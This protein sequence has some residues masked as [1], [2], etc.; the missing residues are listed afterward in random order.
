MDLYIPLLFQLRSGLPGDEE[1]ERAE[2]AFGDSLGD[3]RLVIDCV[4]PAQYFDVINR[5]F[6]AV[7]EGRLLLAVLDDAISCY[8]RNMNHTSRSALLQFREVDIWF[9]AR[10]R[11]DLFAFESICDVFG[12]DPGALRSRLRALRTEIKRRA[13]RTQTT[14]DSDLMACRSCNAGR[15]ATQAPNGIS[16]ARMKPDSLSSVESTL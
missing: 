8:L 7:A 14:L 13:R 1:F 12:I 3:R 10:N 4:L 16:G 15:S 9:S 5:R 11:R 6:S 2:H